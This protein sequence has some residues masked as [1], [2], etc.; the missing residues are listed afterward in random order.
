M[1]G[2]T[3]PATHAIHVLP[4]NVYETALKRIR[5]VWDEFGSITV[6]FSG[7]KDSTSVMELCLIVARERDALPLR[8]AWLDQECEF[9]ATE[10]YA[11]WVAD[12]PEIDFRWHQIPFRLFNATDHA[13]P[14]LNVWGEGEEWVREKDPRA[15]WVNDYGTDRFT[16]LLDAIGDRYGGAWLTGVRT[17]ESPARR[18]GLMSYAGY[19]WVTWNRKSKKH[20]VFHP[21]YDWTYRDVWKAIYDGNNPAEPGTQSWRYNS[22]YDIQFQNGVPVR[23][24]RVS[25]YHHETA[26]HSLFYLQE[27]EPETWEKATRRLEGIS[28][29]GHIGKNDFYV[30]DLPFMFSTWQEYHEYLVQNLI[31]DPEH[32]AIFRKHRTDLERRLPYIDR[33]EIAKSAVQAVI[34]N[35]YHYTKGNQFYVTHM[36]PTKHPNPRRNREPGAPRIKKDSAR[37]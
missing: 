25:N 34:A 21:I 19:K 33:E 18:L 2:V 23:N 14:W 24:M 3:R 16:E 8:V 20:I 22:F 10:R 15:I 36:D 13:H 26:V 31:Q 30:G 35:D 5:W 28:T 6:G 17:E 1:A 7:G 37:A 11:S 12:R 9:A 4:G 29:A 32:Q 27:A